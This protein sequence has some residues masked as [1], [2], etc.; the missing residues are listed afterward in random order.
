MDFLGGGTVNNESGG[1]ISGANFGVYIVGGSAATNS[2][3]NTG[4]IT[5]AGTNS[6]GVHL[7]LG[8]PVTNQS[9][10]TISGVANGVFIEGGTGSVINGGNIHG[11][12]ASANG[13]VLLGGGTATNTG[14]ITGGNSW[15]PYRWRRRVT[16]ELGR[17]IGDKSGRRG[18]SA[19]A[20]LSTTRAAGRSA[21]RTS[22][23]ISSAAARRRTRS[24][25]REGSPARGRTVRASIWARAAR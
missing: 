20:V 24:P 4:G 15:R 21:A 3:T 6:S 18:P 23:S 2:V 1:S 14:T 22:A 19:A 8:R 12:A 5:G 17:D 16:D 7:G 11:T 25:I 10:G 9:G 13:V